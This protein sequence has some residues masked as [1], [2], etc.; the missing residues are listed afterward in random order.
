MK[1]FFLIILISIFIFSGC[2]KNVESMENKINSEIEFLENRILEILG[3]YENSEYLENGKL[4]WENI[5][6][7]FNVIVNNF[8]VIEQDLIYSKIDNFKLNLIKENIKNI[9][10]NIRINNDINTKIE[11]TN[12]YINILNIKDMDNIELK[13]LL[14]QELNYVYTQNTMNI[15][16]EIINIENKYKEELNNQEFKRKNEY[17]LVRFD[18]NLEDAKELISKSNYEQLPVILIELIEFL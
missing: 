10:E 2:S 15:Q 3:K 18:N 12:L 1:K 11:L 13:K 4:N 16:N 9:L 5:S 14:V 17:I 7:D 6:Y 8:E